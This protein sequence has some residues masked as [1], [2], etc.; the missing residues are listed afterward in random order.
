M[1]SYLKYSKVLAVNQD[2]GSI[3]D[4]HAAP[5]ASQPS[6]GHRLAPEMQR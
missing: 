5:T 2:I 4:A 1:Y 6:S 3:G